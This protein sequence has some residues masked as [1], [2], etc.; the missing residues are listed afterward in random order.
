MFIYHLPNHQGARLL[1]IG[2]GRKAP[3]PTAGH[4]QKNQKISYVINLS[5]FI[6]RK[7][8][9][10]RVIIPAYQEPKWTNAAEHPTQHGG[11]F[12]ARLS[13]LQPG[14]MLRRVRYIVERVLEVE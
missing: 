12:V 8:G 11:R 4:T 3:I 13:H 10:E 1:S 9:E 6:Q 5:P 7:Q 2:T 14:R